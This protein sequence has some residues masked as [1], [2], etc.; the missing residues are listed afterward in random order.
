MYVMNG[1]AQLRQSIAQDVF[2]YQVLEDALSHYRKPRDRARLLVDHGEIVRVKKGLY[3][4]GE[5]FRREAISREYLANLVF[6]PSYVSLESALSYYGFIPERVNAVTSVVLGRSHHFETPF[7]LFT[8]HGLTRQRYI[9]GGTLERIGNERFLIASPEKALIDKVWTDKRFAG[10]TQA[11]F[12]EYLFDD[13]RIDEA[14]LRSLSDE[15]LAIVRDSFNSPKI[16]NLTKFIA[17]LKRTV[18]E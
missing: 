14:A 9:V 12:A 11:E 13:L 3:V 16:G 4:F 6:G 8:Y 18:H 5:P 10:S 17:R 15:R 7:G 1:I 2:D